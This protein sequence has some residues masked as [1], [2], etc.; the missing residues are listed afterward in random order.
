MA[1]TEKKRDFLL[2]NTPKLFRK[3]GFR[4]GLHRYVAVAS[5]RSSGELADHGLAFNGKVVE[6]MQD[7]GR[8]ATRWYK[9]FGSEN[10]SLMAVEIE[11]SMVFLTKSG[12]ISS[13]RFGVVS[14]LISISFLLATMH[15]NETLHFR[16]SSEK[17][18]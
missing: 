8:E 3:I 13:G 12:E 4:F 18:R 17:W 15:L 7:Q 9:N 14:T 5:L 11:S 2:I 16:L 6:R 1:I 10:K